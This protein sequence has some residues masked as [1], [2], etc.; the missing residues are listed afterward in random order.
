MH[1]IYQRMLTEILPAIAAGDAE[2]CAQVEDFGE[3]LTLSGACLTFTLPA[4]FAFTVALHNADN[5]P[6]GRIDDCRDNYEQFRELLFKHPPNATLAPFGLQV[7][8][9]L[10]DLDPD[11]IVYRLARRGEGP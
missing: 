3:G 1:R 4:L 9:A 10:A 8:I 11:L 5:G 6:G 7:G 2:L